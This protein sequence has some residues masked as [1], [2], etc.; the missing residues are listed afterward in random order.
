[1][2]EVEGGCLSE[3]EV[4]DFVQGRLA[5]AELGPV[6]A[7]I[8]ECPLCSDL[9]AATASAWTGR[10]DDVPTRVAPL[11]GGDRPSPLEAV[12]VQRRDSER[13]FTAGVLQPD[14]VLRDTYRIV[15]FI[16]KGG[17]GEV[18]EARHARLSG[19]YAV[20]VLSTQAAAH[21]AALARF[22]REAEIT[23][24]LQHPNIV[25][26]IDFD[27]TP[28]GQP[29]L[30][31]EYLVG[32]NLGDHLKRHGKL[33]IA[34]V[35]TLLEPIV[36]ALAAVHGR[37]M[38]HRDLKPQN[39]FL[40]TAEGSAVTVK[41]LD[42]GLSKVRAASM[43]VS[44]DA[45]LLGTPMYMAPEQAKGKLD[46]V[47][48]AADQFALGALV[49]EMLTGK[50][51][52]AGETVESIIYQVV[53]D[54]PPRLEKV[55][56]EL[57]PGVGVAVH[58]ALAKRVEDRYPSVSDLLADLRRAVTEG[59]GA[60]LPSQPGRDAGPAAP[61]PP[62]RSVLAVVVGLG[63]A[64][65]I[66][67]G[68]WAMRES[69]PSPVAPGSPPG[70]MPGTGPPAFVP[71]SPPTPPAVREEQTV[72]APRVLAGE[73]AAPGP[74]AATAARPSR[75]RSPGR[76][77]ARRPAA[78]AAATAPAAEPAILIPV[79]STLETATA[80]APPLPEERIPAAQKRRLFRTLGPD[81]EHADGGASPP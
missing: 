7:H 32:H 55:A 12:T 35:M 17:I 8:G 5:A 43:V 51:P 31:M 49:Y 1:L 78:G 44:A 24:G 3:Q 11:E 80:A 38:V 63:L 23:S 15:R 16:D 33:P 71:P 79:P 36:S 52:F 34:E 14:T 47:G 2:E 26:V 56:P 54:E 60:R 50:A 28:A 66:G 48:P 72:P 9:V 27:Q 25:Q 74:A 29:Y 6:E 65:A 21:P 13:R 58:R 73:E 64:A 46:E 81:G 42:F 41:L 75:P 67:V 10:A 69:P 30:V 68:F 57:P 53:H 22:R 62:L 40:Q 77:G 70:A 37:G 76:D 18:Y 45:M 39:V 19:R 61:S 59:A 20:K 4:M